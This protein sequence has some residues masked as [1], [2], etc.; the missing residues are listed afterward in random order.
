MVKNPSTHPPQNYYLCPASKSVHEMDGPWS[1]IRPPQN[2][3]L[4]PLSESVHEMDG[5]SQKS[6]SFVHM[7]RWTV[8]KRSSSCE[9]A[10]VASI[11][12]NFYRDLNSVTNIPKI[13]TK[14][15][16]QTS[17]LPTFAQFFF[18]TRVAP[19]SSKI[20]QSAIRT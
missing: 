12:P 7:G 11:S 13:V 15:K 6:W 14:F 8:R 10:W 17:L 5:L 9:E 1:K 3:H 2:Y 4:G 16:P 20:V 18:S 19:F